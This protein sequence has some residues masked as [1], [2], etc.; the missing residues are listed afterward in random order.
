MD[1]QVPAPKPSLCFK[2]LYLQQPSWFWSRGFWLFWSC[3]SGIF[4]V[5][6]GMNELWAV[7]WLTSS[8]VLNR[9]SQDCGWQK[10]FPELAALVCYCLRNL[11]LLVLAFV[12]HDHTKYTA[13]GQWLLLLRD[14]FLCFNRD[15]YFNCFWLQ[16][17]IWT[18]SSVP[19]TLIEDT[20]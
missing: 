12:L 15:P 18:I 9:C 7:A 8:F 3:F 6:E 13:L 17:K 16:R 14:T 20:Y 10:S 11:C 4:S 19:R 5:P 1:P 2:V